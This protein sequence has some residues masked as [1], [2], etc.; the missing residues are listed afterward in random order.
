MI[1][2][3][4]LSAAQEIMFANW[5]PPCRVLVEH[6][7]EWFSIFFLLYR[8]QDSD[9]EMIIHLGT[10]MV[11]DGFCMIWCRCFN[12][13]P[14]QMFI[15]CHFLSDRWHSLTKPGGMSFL[16]LAWENPS[17]FWH[18]WNNFVVRCIFWMR[19]VLGFAVLNVVNAVFVWLGAF[20]PVKNQL[21][22]QQLNPNT[23]KRTKVDIK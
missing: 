1:M 11:F 9:S 3:C 14:W 19:C 18:P 7:S 16:F 13:Q 21:K 10:K 4:F 2:L 17:L 20:G 6:V 8:C 12:N 22:K 23:W 15:F 5:S